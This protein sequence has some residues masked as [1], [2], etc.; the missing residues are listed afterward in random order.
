MANMPSTMGSRCSCSQLG[1]KKSFGPGCVRTEQAGF[2]VSDP[3]YTLMYRY[4][5]GQSGCSGGSTVV[6]RRRFGKS[7]CMFR[8]TRVSMRVGKG[9]RFYKIAVAI[10]LPRRLSFTDR[11][12][13]TR[14]RRI[15]GDPSGSTTFDHAVSS[16]PR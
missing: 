5:P 15:S 9:G 14:P 2:A 4:T 12:T 10:Y 8:W 11:N 13:I 3:G 7:N 16:T 6:G 1:T